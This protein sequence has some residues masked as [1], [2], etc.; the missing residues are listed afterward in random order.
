[1]K[2]DIVPIGIITKIRNLVRK[3]DEKIENTLFIAFGILFL[4]ILQ[5]NIF[6]IPALFTI[7]IATIGFAFIIHGLFE[8]WTKKQN[9]FCHNCG[10]K[11]IKDAEYCLNCGE[12]LY[13][14]I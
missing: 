5:L 13:G 7:Y 12:H 10:T 3:M 6:Q 4:V 9:T 1:M 14:D 11:I 2:I 8:F